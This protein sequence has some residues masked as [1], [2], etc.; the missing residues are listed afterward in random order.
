MQV[1]DT[2]VANVPTT[3]QELVLH[4][5]NTTRENNGVFELMY[6]E[7]RWSVADSEGVNGIPFISA[8][9][10]RV[11]T[12]LIGTFNHTGHSRGFDGA[13][14]VTIPLKDSTR[15]SPEV[16]A[17]GIEARLI[18][19]EAALGRGDAGTWLSDLNALR[20]SATS[21]GVD[22]TLAPLAD[23]GAGGNARILLT[24]RERAFWLYAS[25]HR[26]GDMRRLTRPTDA[27]VAGYG[28]DPNSVYPIGVWKGTTTNFGS[29]VNFPIPFEE[30]NNPNFNAAQCDVTQP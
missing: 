7:K 1:A 23:P 24:M 20:S 28:L 5:E 18:Q 11:G 13:T 17:S 19:A 3:F 12:E 21:L 25:A 2:V 16:L 6:S 10:P 26:L 8:H 9:D 22:S 30:G 27:P 15:S 4:S 14:I 29:E